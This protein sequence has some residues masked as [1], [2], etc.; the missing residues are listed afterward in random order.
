[1]ICPH[2]NKEY[3]SLTQHI[4]KAHLHFYIEINKNGEEPKMT[5]T[6]QDGKVLIKDDTAESEGENNGKTFWTF[7]FESKA[8]EGNSVTLTEDGEVTVSRDVYNE[9]TGHI[10]SMTKAFKNWS[11][12]FTAPKKPTRKLRK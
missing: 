10:T 8:G 4:T 5:V 1:M 9:T 11:V 12:K 6:N 7:Y 3:K 2:C